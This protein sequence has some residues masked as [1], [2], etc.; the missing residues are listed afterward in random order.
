M[1][2]QIVVLVAG[3]VVLLAFL[4][5]TFRR[6][7]RHAPGRARPGHA[8]LALVD[9]RVARRRRGHARPARPRG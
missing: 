8:S 6:R 3:A 4:L 5:T 2:V 1:G 9:R 7:A